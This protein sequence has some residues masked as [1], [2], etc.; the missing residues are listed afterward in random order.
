[1]ARSGMLLLLFIPLSLA[2]NP[3]HGVFSP[4]SLQ[5]AKI[6]GVQVSPGSRPDS[7]V[8]RYP[9]REEP[10]SL[11]IPVPA[12]AR[13]WTGWGAFTFEFRSSS[14]IRW[15]LTIRNRNGQEF[16]YRIQPMAGVRVKAVIPQAFLTREYMN[17]RQFRGYWLSSWANHIDLTD[18]ESLTV[19][20]APNQDVTLELGPLA[21]VR[22]T[23]QDEVY[24]D[25]PVVDRFGQWA[26]AGWPN[27]VRSIEDLEQAWKL[28]DQEVIQAP[29]FGFCRYGG[30]KEGKQQSTGFFQVAKVDGR[31]WLTDPEGH[32]FFSTGM[33]C[34]R[35]TDRTR[36]TGREM[37]FEKIPPGSGATAD[38]YRANAGLRYG[39]EDFVDAWKTTI[40]RRLRWWGFNTVANWSDPALFV[41]PQVP[42]VT[43]VRIGGSRKSWQ[44]FPDVYSEEF[45]RQA[46]EDARQQCAPL[47]D[48]WYL[49]GYFIGNEPRWPYRNLV[50]L[51]LN[52]PEPSATQAFAT[53]KLEETGDTPAA[54]EALL[55]TL[56]RQYFQTVRD[57]IRKADPNHL[58]LGIRFAGQAPDPVLRASD[59]FDVYS[60]NIYRFEP[61][62][63]QI[64]RIAAALDKPILIGEFHFGAAERGY[65]PSLVMVKNQ[66]ERGVAYQYYLE[67]AAALPAIIG[68][69]YFQM[70]DQPVSGRFDSENYNLGFVNQLDI[71]YPEMV[72][73][74]RATHRRIY[75]VHA[76]ALEP[77]TRQARV[78]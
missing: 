11:A 5:A 14:T 25:R 17:N 30:W 2:A 36:V 63:D 38:F 19:A 43:N 52:D 13:D 70:V 44:A 67:R 16:S 66:T 72:S 34:V 61:P 51:I 20:M 57:A 33:D 55:E 7:L 64:R 21:L 46:A 15:T 45:A 78:R 24:L 27:K 77:V 37:L 73:F 41:H 71:P 65:A 76:G 74:A 59:V 6:S 60:I 48:Q 54:R 32:L 3:L 31:W 28:E 9:S 50:D 58:V 35:Y 56:S 62:V 49:I 18:V 47:R 68:A 42:F 26:L 10:A 75:P 69:H 29:D 40:W 12:A 4:E 8:L 22:E 1:M 23:P 53:K 39:E